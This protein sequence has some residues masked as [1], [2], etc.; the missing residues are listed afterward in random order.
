MSDSDLAPAPVEPAPDPLGGGAGDADRHE[1]A[2][3]QS[4]DAPSPAEEDLAARL[5][6][7]TKLGEAKG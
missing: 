3:D 4:S 5:D 1:S 7:A 2:A 6:P